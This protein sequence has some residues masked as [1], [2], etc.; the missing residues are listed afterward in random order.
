MSAV[1]QL[2]FAILGV[3]IL[4]ACLA[5]SDPHFGF[6]TV[7]SSDPSVNQYTLQSCP[8]S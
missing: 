1:E 4:A 6:A 7:L 3:S 2:L 5:L 8:S